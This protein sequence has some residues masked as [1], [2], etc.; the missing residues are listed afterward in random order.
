MDSLVYILDVFPGLYC[1][2][3]D[4][5]KFLPDKVI[6]QPVLLV[7]FTPRTARRG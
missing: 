3:V 7:S 1:S 2:R 4:V 6:N 5:D